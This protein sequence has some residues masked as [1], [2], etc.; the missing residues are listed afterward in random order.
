MMYSEIWCFHP[1]WKIFVKIGSFPQGSGWKCRKYLEKKTPP[2]MKYLLVDVF[3]CLPVLKDPEKFRLKKKMQIGSSRKSS[4]CGSPSTL[5][6]SFISSR[7]IP[8]FPERWEVRR[9]WQLSRIFLGQIWSTGR[10]WSQQPTVGTVGY[11]LGWDCPPS[12]DA[13]VAFSQTWGWD[14][15]PKNGS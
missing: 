7:W 10:Y 8:N 15:E 2:R 5:V 14:P 12:Q 1:I 11:L 13:I 3:R 9:A 4:F 6:V